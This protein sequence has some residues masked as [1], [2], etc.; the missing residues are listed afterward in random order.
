[1]ELMTNQE[2]FDKV[3]E[4][5]VKQGKPSMNP[6]KSCSYY[7]NGNRCAVGWL[8]DE[9]TAKKLEEYYPGNDVYEIDRENEDY[10]MG[11]DLAFLSALQ[12]AHDNSAHKEGWMDDWREEMMQIA[13]D[14]Y[15][16]KTVFC[17]LFQEVF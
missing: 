11:Y 4:A 1:M 15:L 8:M 14:F 3:A 2:I 10:F 6:D 7:S 5:L 17:G 16:D 12:C 9:S 13:D